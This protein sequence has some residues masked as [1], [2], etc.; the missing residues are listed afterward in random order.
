MKL[1][2]TLL[3]KLTSRNEPLLKPGDRVGLFEVICMDKIESEEQLQ[4]YNTVV[5][6]IMYNHSSH[7]FSFYFVNLDSAV[8]FLSHKF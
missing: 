6:N 4:L 3:N 1:A 2:Y 8:T 5:C 7:Y